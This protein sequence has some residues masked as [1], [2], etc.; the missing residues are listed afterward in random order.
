MILGGDSVGRE[1]REG[2]AGGDAFLGGEAGVAGAG[3]GAGGV[4]GG[5]DLVGEARV[6][7]VNDSLGR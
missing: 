2:V 3:A 6:E 1:E 4:V 5:P 7:D